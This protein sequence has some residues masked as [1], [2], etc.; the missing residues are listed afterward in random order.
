MWPAVGSWRPD[1]AATNRGAIAA[2]SKKPTGGRRQAIDADAVVAEY[3]AWPP[4]VGRP[5]PGR[6]PGPD[7]RL[8]HLAGRLRTRRSGPGGAR[9][10]GPSGAGL[11]AARAD[12]QAL[13]AEHGEPGLG[14]HRQLLP[15]NRRRPTGGGPGGA[16]PGRA[17]GIGEGQPAAVLAS[18]RGLPVGAGPGDRHGVLLHRATSLRA[19]RP[20]G[21]RSVGLGP[22][23]SVAG[24]ARGRA[25]PTREV[26]LNSV[27]R[28]AIDEWTTARTD[29]V[30]AG[31]ATSSPPAA[32]AA[33]WLSRS[34][35][36]ISA[37]VIDLIIRRLAK[38]AHLELSAHTL[39][40]G[41]S[42]TAVGTSHR[43][44]R[45]RPAAAE[46]RPAGLRHLLS[47]VVA[48]ARC[49]RATART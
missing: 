24:F 22:P 13:G 2:R 25:T 5:E 43:A 38:D 21:G 44:R 9:R 4:A 46:V 16:G 34:E 36:R 42:M 14:G 48:G 11:Q 28:H 49:G 32:S 10:P 1:G 33:L 8:P 39:L 31:A 23:G 15:L 20:R 17:P 41:P 26:P 7:A 18:G 45:G 40:E 35:S 19:G 29:Q 30:A 27:C 6:L 47:V 12:G 37:R 3:A